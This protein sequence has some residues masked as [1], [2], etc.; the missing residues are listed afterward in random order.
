MLAVPETNTDHGTSS[1]VKGSGKNYLL[2]N[3]SNIVI[4]LI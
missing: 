4:V 3:I 2:V 1:A